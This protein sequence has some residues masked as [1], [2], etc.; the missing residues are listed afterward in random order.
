MKIETLQRQHLFSSSVSDR[1][2]ECLWRA[3]PYFMTHAEVVEAT[4]CGAKAVDWAMF[5]L[6]R[7]GLTKG[8]RRGERLEYRAMPAKVDPAQKP[9][10]VDAAKVTIESAFS[11]VHDGQRGCDGHLKPEPMET[12]WLGQGFECSALPEDACGART[13][14]G[15]PC[16]LKSIYWNGRCKFHGGLSTGPKSDAG[17]EQARINGR[18]GGRPRKQ[19]ANPTP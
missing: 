11:H 5:L 17:K 2:M 18:K 10:P 7:K 8:R 15:T 4:G 3:A 1:V 16:K 13:R 6:R 14:A 12:L 19:A 9:K